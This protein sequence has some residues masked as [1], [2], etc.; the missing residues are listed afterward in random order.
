MLK[1]LSYFIQCCFKGIKLIKKA[2]KSIDNR[3]FS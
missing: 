2:L 1:K 3:A